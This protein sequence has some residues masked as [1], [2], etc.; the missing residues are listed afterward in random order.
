MKE[1]RSV[2]SSDPKKLKICSAA[3]RAAGRSVGR[4]ESE[5]MAGGDGGSVGRRRK[6]YFQLRT[7]IRQIT[8]S[9]HTEFL[10]CRQLQMSCKNTLYSCILA[11][12]AHTKP[13]SH[14]TLQHFRGERHRRLITKAL[15]VT[16]CGGYWGWTR[17]RL[18]VWR[19]LPA[20]CPPRAS[21]NHL[22]SAA[23]ER[24]LQRLAIEQ[25]VI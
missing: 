19:L 7:A 25:S 17:S 12:H 11:L 20:L 15:Q 1:G 6:V 9:I 16:E 8:K 21:T 2:G 14:E 4:T 18:P 24:L 22:F 5:T 10:R 13:H 3:L 23:S